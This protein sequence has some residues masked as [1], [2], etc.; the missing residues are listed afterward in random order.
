MP[1]AFQLNVPRQY[2]DIVRGT[3]FFDGVALGSCQFEVPEDKL[4]AF[5]GN[6]WC[7]F[8]LPVKDDEGRLSV[9][10]RWESGESTCFEQ[11]LSELIE[12]AIAES[13][14]LNLSG[15]VFPT[16]LTFSMILKGEKAFHNTLLFL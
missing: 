16:T 13:S 11:H 14:K 5:A 6:V 15:V 7:P 3:Q 4:I 10:A 12:K 8:H 1:C 2:V 9:K